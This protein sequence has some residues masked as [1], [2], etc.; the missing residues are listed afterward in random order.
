M[1]AAA[2]HP[3]SPS[4]LTGVLAAALLA[5]CAS[6]PGKEQCVATDWRTVGYEDG[7]R[8]YAA[9]RIGV[10]RA[11]CG[12]HGVTPDL[13][14]YLEG[15]ERGLKEYCLPKNGFRAGLH[16]GAYANV[17]S[18]PTEAAFVDAY[19]SGRQIYD[20]RSALRQTQAQLNR[21]RDGLVQTNTAMANVTAELVL[22]KLPPD[23]RAALATELVRLA[24]ER[25]GLAARIDELTVRS[26]ELAAN[27]QQLERQSP[28]ML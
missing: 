9:E 4:I 7:L 17:C 21:S 12:P 10:H 25:T 26:Q 14:A 28:Y 8:G 3:L 13:T 19:R 23:R 15:R 20:A 2:R 1:D 24:Q 16:G 6:G 22:P 11:A 27:V 5:G 18:G